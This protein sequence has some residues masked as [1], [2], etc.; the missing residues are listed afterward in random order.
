MHG[1]TF[2]DQGTG[3]G[4]FGFI[5]TAHLVAI[6]PKP[7]GQCRHADAANTEKENVGKLIQIMGKL[8]SCHASLR[9]ARRSFL[10][11]FTV[12]LFFYQPQ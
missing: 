10:L 2:G 4:R 12:E 6:G 3:E 9:A 5:V 8:W 11:Q 7:A 1:D